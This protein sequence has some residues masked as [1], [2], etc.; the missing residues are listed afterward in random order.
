MIYEPSECY[1]RNKALQNACCCRCYC[2]GKRTLVFNRGSCAL[3]GEGNLTFSISCLC[4]KTHAHRTGEFFFFL[5]RNLY[6]EYISLGF[7]FEDERRKCPLMN[8]FGKESF[9]F[10]SEC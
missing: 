9:F 2:K 8:F 7:K 6:L 5:T 1:V 3:L 4:L 10:N